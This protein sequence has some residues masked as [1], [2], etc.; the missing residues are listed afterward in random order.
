MPSFGR[1]NLAT[2][3]FTSPLCGI[4]NRPFRLLAKH[5]GAGLTYVEMLKSYSVVHKHPK[6]ME[7]L[8]YFPDEKPLGAQFASHNPDELAEA[9]KLAEDMGFDTIDL[10]SGCPAGR[11]GK[12]LCGARLMSRPDLAAE[13]MRAMR[14]AT[15][16]PVSIK[17]RAGMDDTCLNFLEFGRMAEEEGMDF[18]TLHPR[19]RQQGYKGPALHERTAE[20]VASVKIPVIAS[21]DVTEP[22]HALRLERVAGVA[23]VMVGR[24]LFGKPWLYRR[25]LAAQRG[26]QDPGHPPPREVLA[27]MRWHF[28]GL[29]DVFS[30][31]LSCVL[32][33]RYSGWYIKGIPGAAALRARFVRIETPEE[34]YRV[35]GETD[36]ELA[37]L[38]AEGRIEV[39]PPERLVWEFGRAEN[40]GALIDHEYS[41]EEKAS[42]GG[43]L[44]G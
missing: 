5:Y 32:Q 33:R 26:E 7:L 29:M 40:G 38:E 42:A 43:V 9:C 19:T 16:L 41:A 14:K 17:F 34:F 37:E 36:A 30:P 35:W 15:D 6:A 10:N 11:V 22:E 20:L 25:I 2:N 44:V 24:G 12:E 39:T 21:G 18:I 31:R 8:Q 13:L 23:G 27:V 4:S 28:E 3:L 1:L